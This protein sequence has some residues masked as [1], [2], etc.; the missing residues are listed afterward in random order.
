VTPP[1]DLKLA[2]EECITFTA[3]QVVLQRWLQMLEATS[4]NPRTCG[5]DLSQNV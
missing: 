2:C 5:V 3:E 1:T 4:L